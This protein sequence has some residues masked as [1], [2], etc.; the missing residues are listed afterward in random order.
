M[1]REQDH[2]VYFALGGNVSAAK[3]N[4]LGLSILKE[5]LKE[6]LKQVAEWKYPPFA[7]KESIYYLEILASSGQP[8]RLYNIKVA[9][10][11]P[12]SAE[13]PLPPPKP[14]KATRKL[15]SVSK[16]VML[17]P[18]RVPQFEIAGLMISEKV[19]G[20]YS[21]AGELAWI[22]T[23]YLAE[24]LA[25]EGKFGLQ[26]LKTS[27]GLSLGLDGQVFLSGLPVP[28]LGLQLGGGVENWVRLIGGPIL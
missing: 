13:A 12:P 24:W 14:V 26:V 21:L 4:G 18:L 2:S 23:R 15:A 28:F 17:E 9:E 8:G 25:L 7:G 19:K 1:V 27:T 6:N 16:S 3:I 5:G 20:S 10:A 22:P 11:S